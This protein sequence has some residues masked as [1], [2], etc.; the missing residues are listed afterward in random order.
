MLGGFG[1]AINSSAQ[2]LFYQ[3]AAQQ[4]DGVLLLIMLFMVSGIVG[5]PIWVALSKGREKHVMLALAMVGLAFSYA[6]IPLVPAGHFWA[7]AVI[8]IV[9]GLC[10]A[11]PM[12][13]GSAIMADVIDVDRLALSA[14]RT[15]LFMSVT[16]MVEKTSQAVGLALALIVMDM[17][18]GA[19]AAGYVYGLVPGLFFLAVV[20]LALKFPLTRD[21]LADVQKQLA[22]ISTDE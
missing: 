4:G 17:L 8:E 7:Y 1:G 2:V 13:F 5:M 16:G 15:A 18:G 12:I 20:P 14:D 10:F 9:A 19:S 21:Q 22:T 6:M 3:N 11:A